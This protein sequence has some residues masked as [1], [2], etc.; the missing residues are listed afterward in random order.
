MKTEMRILKIDLA[1]KAIGKP[2]LDIFV[3]HCLPVNFLAKQD[4]LRNINKSFN[5][6]KQL[7]KFSE[8]MGLFSFYIPMTRE[9]IEKNNYKKNS[10]FLLEG[11]KSE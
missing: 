5:V 7:L 8:N 11:K 1:K 3:V 6:D 4:V 9:E 2:L 10:V